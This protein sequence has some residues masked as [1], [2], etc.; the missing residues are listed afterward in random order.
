MSN[1]YVL[2]TGLVMPTYDSIRADLE[3]DF[4]VAFGDDIDVSDQALFG[5]I[6]AIIAKWVGK[7]FLMGQ[8]I[9]TSRDP[10]QAEGVSLDY[11]I[12]ENNMRRLP[13]LPT[14]VEN[15]ILYATPGSTIPAGKRAKAL[16]Q[17]VEYVLD[18]DVLIFDPAVIYAKIELT[19]VTTGVIY[20]I[21]IN[22][23]TYAYTALGG[24]TVNDVLS[25]IK[26]LIEAGSWTGT[27]TVDG[28]YII[29]DDTVQFDVLSSNMSTIL[30]GNYGNFSCA[31]TGAN[32]LPANSLTEI[33][34]AATG[35][36]SLINPTPGVLGRAIESDT[37]TRI[38]REY[39]ISNG[40]GTEEAIR[41]RLLDTVANVT[42][43][44]VVSNRTDAVDGDGRPPHSFEAIVV[45]G[46][47]TDIANTLWNVA[48]QGI[49][50]TGSINSDGSTSPT[51]PGSGILITDSQGYSQ[52]IRFSRPE[53]VY[54]WV[55]LELSLY[56]EE[57]YPTNGD[58]LVKAAIIDWSLQ[59]T[60]I[61]IG[62]DVIR[63]RLSIPIYTIPGIEDIT[64]ELFGSTNSG[65][66]PTYTETNITISSRQVAV[67]TLSKITITVV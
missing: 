13:A 50:F 15:A 34:T 19:S 47:K 22:S 23:I 35:W 42:Q 9:Y 52:L 36:Q 64:I 11:I 5:Q 6:I 37:E 38:R 10:D 49:M 56:S 28:N 12:A 63:Q 45:G 44:I 7:N 62:K 54:I 40:N 65:A 60:N 31:E 24:D 55:N 29:L 53:S 39:S 14:T 26:T 66:T 57:D 2:S 61:T 17:T 51:I 27:V 67:F 3:V 58:D 8:E 32:S 48:A 33:V 16:N 18:A 25:E 1:V 41:D 20:S 43:A 21:A 30:E 4:K 46:D 59:N